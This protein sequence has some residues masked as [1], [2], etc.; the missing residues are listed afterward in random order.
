MTPFDAWLSQCTALGPGPAGGLGGASAAFARFAADYARL[1]ATPSASPADWE[2]LARALTSALLPT[3]PTEPASGPAQAGAAAL[4]ALAAATAVG[5]ARRLGAPA[6]PTTLR[7]TFDAW[8]DA[9]EEAFRAAA[10]SADFT[11]ALAAQCNDAVRLRAV[12]QGLVDDAARLVGLPS[13]GEV[14]A[15]HDTVRELR[16]QLEAAIAT[17][18][19]RRQRKTP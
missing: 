4:A 17:P 3:G 11:R 19:A 2:S 9:A 6:S 18:R 16:G 1:A 12:Q 7:G 5:F 10:F 8:I 14:D 13:R 15:L